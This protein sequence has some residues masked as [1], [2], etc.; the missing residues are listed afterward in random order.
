MTNLTNTKTGKDFTGQVTADLIC[1][2]FDYVSET[3]GRQKALSVDVNYPFITGHTGSGNFVAY[4]DLY[5]PTIYLD[6]EDGVPNY[7]LDGHTPTFEN[8]GLERTQEELDERHKKVVDY[9]SARYLN[10]HG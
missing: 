4:K 1:S 9:F 7:H 6:C 2:V 3:Y 5:G 10:K 8:G